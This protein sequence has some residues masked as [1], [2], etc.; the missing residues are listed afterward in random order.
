MFQD[1]LSLSRRRFLQAVT[2]GTA[3]TAGGTLPRSS[4]ASASGDL[5]DDGSTDVPGG[6]VGDLERV[7]IVGAG[8]AGLAAANALANAGVEVV[9][10]EARERIGGRAKTRDFGGIPVDQGC[11]WIHSPAGNPMTQWAEQLGVS[12]T[13]AEF[14]DD[15]ATFSGFD[16]ETGPLTPF[17]IV[18]TFIYT[19]L[20]D[21]GFDDLYASLGE[22]PTLEDAI[23][24]FLDLQG[25]EGTA[26]R[27]ADAV[28][29][30][31][32]ESS[33]AA[34]VND[35]SV[36]AFF[37]FP[38]NPN[39]YSGKDV[40]P[41]GGYR[42]LYEPLAAG[43]DVRQGHRVTKVEYGAEGVVVRT[44][45]KSRR[46]RKT[47][48]FRGSHVIVTLPL[49][50]LKAARTNFEP[51]LPIPKVRAIQ[52]MGV[53]YL[54]KISLAFDEPFWQEGGKTHLFYGSTVQG[55][56]PAFLD[57][58]RFSGGA[59]L[60]SFVAGDFGRRMSQMS[61]GEIKARTLEILR[62]VYGASVPKPR[63]TL[64]TR[65]F[66]DPFTRGSYSSLPVG[67]TYRDM[68]A[69]AEPVAGRLLFAGEATNVFQSATADGA[70]S[71]GVR[72]AKRLLGQSTVRLC[73]L[74]GAGSASA[75]PSADLFRRIERWRR[76]LV[77]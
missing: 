59:V 1:P 25:L 72:E 43:V 76:R 9:V 34:A 19:L 21:N 32:N 8:F 36:D 40:F 30:Y 29:R 7:I 71:S 20:F 10:L 68:E 44:R 5:F 41:S 27:R 2:A 3:A 26:L 48:E 31:V 42:S 56:F 39:S 22:R 61:R 11:S 24:R 50:V 35:I 47:R 18:D 49:G 77:A 33:F 70:F 66:S 28:L 64:I 74:E 62:E 38:S 51:L 17:E 46:G 57:L 75:D 6:V 14:A 52:R 4:W 67:S 53:G 13:T 73:P 63:E 54:E 55:E 15:I 12:A 45:V 58:Q 65:W 16:A 37:D 60:Q 69:L 23:L